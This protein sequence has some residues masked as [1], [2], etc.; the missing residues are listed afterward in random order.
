MSTVEREGRNGEPIVKTFPLNSK[1]LTAEV[2]TRIAKGLGLP[3]NA[4]AAETRQLIE[5]IRKLEEQEHEPRNIQ[6]DEIEA[7]GDIT[8]KLRGE[9]GIILEVT[10]DQR[11]QGQ[12]EETGDGV[13][14]GARSVGGN[15]ESGAGRARGSEEGSVHQETEEQRAELERAQER[16][17]ELEQ[18]L[19]GTREEQERTTE[20]LTQEV[21]QLTAKVKEEKDKYSMLW[22]L[23]CA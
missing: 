16:T 15:E 23:N 11:G 5:G 9:N 4:S 19:E 18:E 2:L 1:R 8:V 14:A 12:E 3:V 6:V 22:R 7:S 20:R 10:G 17:V 13:L 21:N